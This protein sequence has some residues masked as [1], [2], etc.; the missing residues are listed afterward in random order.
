MNNVVLRAKGINRQFMLPSGQYLSVIKDL[1]LELLEGESV[2][3]IG[4]SGC[5]KT[6]LLHILGGIETIDSGTIDPLP[7]DTWRPG[8]VFQHHYLMAELS[9]IE[10]V[11]LAGRIAGQTK[12]ESFSSSKEIL[13]DL[14][15]GERLDHMPNE[16]SGGEMARV[17]IARALVMKPELV[18]ADEPTGDLDEERSRDI[19]EVLF[20]A[21]RKYAKA[22]LIVT[23]DLSLARK[24]DRCLKL[25]KGTI[26]SASG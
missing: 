2:S 25:E 21:V 9:A 26:L 10:N 20:D 22:L 5:G 8:I 6:T 13:F 14:G 19:Q 4:S 16:L 3:I 11:A 15:L 24:A 18:L 12:Q 1:N 7:S 23:H 17:A